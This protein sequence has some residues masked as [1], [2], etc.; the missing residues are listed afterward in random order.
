MMDEQSV[1][2][3]WKGDALSK[4]LVM[5]ALGTTVIEANPVKC[6]FLMMVSSSR[7]SEAVSTII[8][9]GGRFSGVLF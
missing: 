6:E 1:D 3:L 4:R 7:L 8:E 2:I 5:D 9:A